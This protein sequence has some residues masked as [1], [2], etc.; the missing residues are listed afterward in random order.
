LRHA[1]TK[2]ERR[3]RQ[4][5]QMARADGKPLPEH[6]LSSQEALWQRAKRLDD[7]AA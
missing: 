3:F 2:F 1:N 7:T 6:D 5:E 4:M